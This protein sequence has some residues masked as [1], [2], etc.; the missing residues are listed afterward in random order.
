MDRGRAF[1]EV[2]GARKIAS[3]WL[4]QNY[5]L[6]LLDGLDEVG[7]SMQPDC[8]AA[9]NDF[10]EESNPSGLVVCCRLNEYR[11]LP[12]RLKLNG[13]IRLE[14]LSDDEVAEYF[15]Q[16]GTH[17]VA[18]REAVI[19]DPVLRE[20]AET[21]LMLSIMSLAFQGASSNEL[22]ARREIHR[23][24][25]KADPSPLRRNDDPTERNDGSCVPKG[26]DHR[27]ALVAGREDEGAFAVGIP[28]RGT[29]TEL[30]RH[31]GSRS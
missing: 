5:L 28:C 27:V 13:A 15:A 26:E 25:S 9:I 3:Y 11:W 21:P 10:I 29:P 6:P 30:V 24:W 1:G 8:V 16:G 4:E 20:L 14:P 12:E 2:S 18:L 17:L 22:P 31:A 7:T 19:T 23:G